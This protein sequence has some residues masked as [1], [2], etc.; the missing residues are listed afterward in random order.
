M[1][2]KH[3]A[4][5]QYVAEDLLAKLTPSV[6]PMFGGH[7]FYSGGKMFALEADGKIYFKVDKATQKD[8][9]EAGSEPF[10]YSSKDRK[11]VTMSYWTVPE[12]VLEDHELAVTWAKKA[13]KVALNIRKKP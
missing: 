7:G 10:R 4:F 8:F 1:P 13:I 6:R 12:T 9:E 5:V 2:S 11:S 3:A